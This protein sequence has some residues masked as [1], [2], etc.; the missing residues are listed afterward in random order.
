MLYDEEPFRD[1]TVFQTCRAARLLFPYS[2]PQGQPSFRSVAFLAPLLPYP[3]PAT[4]QSYFSL[5]PFLPRVPSIFFRWPPSA[6]HTNEYCTAQKTRGRYPGNSAGSYPRRLQS[7]YRWPPRSGNISTRY[8][9]LPVFPEKWPILGC[10]SPYRRSK[11]AASSFRAVL[12][13]WYPSKN[14]AGWG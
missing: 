9:D 11:R 4:H 12:P 14:R 6:I 10:H 13:V 7:P 8:R 1:P 2:P 3:P 5:H